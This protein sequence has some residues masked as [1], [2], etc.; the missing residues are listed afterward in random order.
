MQFSHR[1]QLP[2]GA[3]G[4]SPK[5]RRW[6]FFYFLLG[7]LSACAAL[8]TLSAIHRVAGSRPASLA[9]RHP[10]ALEAAAALRI[11]AQPPASA[12]SSQQPPLGFPSAL[13]GGP[14]TRTAGARCVILGARSVWRGYVSKDFHAL[15]EELSGGYGWEYLATQHH[16]WDYNVSRAFTSW[17]QVADALGGGP[18]PAVLLVMEVWG[19]G[20]WGARDPRLEGTAVWFWV[21]D[22]HW[23]SEEQRGRKAAVLQP[24]AVDLVVGNYA[25]LLD[26]YFPAAAQLPRL[27][28]PHAAS[29]HFLLPLNSAPLAKVLL[30][31]STEAAFYPYRALVAAKVAAGDARFVQLRHPGYSPAEMAVNNA[32]TG[33]HFAAALHRHLAVLTDGLTLNYTVAKCFEIPATGALLLVNSE[34]TPHLAPLG[35]A[36]GVHFVEYTRDTLDAVVD[37]VLE[38]ANRAA[39][40]A[41][42]AQ[43]QALVWTRH[44]VHHRAAALD[45][46]ARTSAAALAASAQARP[47][48]PPPQRTVDAVIFS[49]DRPLRLLALLESRARHCRNAGTVAVVAHASSA[50]LRA[51]YQRLQELHPGIRFFSRGVLGRARAPPFAPPHWLRCAA[52]QA[53]TSCP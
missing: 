15:F 13:A 52:C 23:L 1:P 11:L 21:D 30:A 46:A 37:W 4:N 35:F 6:V 12:S 28:L 19:L 26:S 34:L 2:A 27:H 20:Q 33:A 41:M 40:D 48:S 31:G 45:A 10:A 18:A 24:G 16:P 32:T 5:G 51:A 42:R 39:V 43:G 14:A 25:P 17:G 47:S 49:K 9:L 7:A 44:T 3:V 53:P 22:L 29:A 50:P 38:E 8:S 36:P